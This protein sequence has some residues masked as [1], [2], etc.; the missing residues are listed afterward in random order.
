M[1]YNPSKQVKDQHDSSTENSTKRDPSNYGSANKDEDQH[2]SST[3]NPTQ[4]EPSNQGSANQD[5]EDQ[6]NSLTQSE[7][8]WD[9]LKWDEIDG[10]ALVLQPKASEREEVLV[11]DP[12]FVVRNATRSDNSADGRLLEVRGV[13]GSKIEYVNPHH[14]YVRTVL[15]ICRPTITCNAT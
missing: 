13:R 15:F 10:G 3:E 12:I 1:R 11:P 7:I 9:P 4:R 6:H 2:D 8:Q 5:E 14:S